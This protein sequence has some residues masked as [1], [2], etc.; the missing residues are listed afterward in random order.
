MN[1]RLIALKVFGQVRYEAGHKTTFSPSARII[2]TNRGGPCR[3]RV[4]SHCRIEGELL[5]FAHGGTISIGDWCFIGPGTRIWSGKSITLGNR[6]LVAHNVNIFDNLTHPIDP[7]ER[8]QHF[9]HILEHGHPRDISLADAPVVIEDDVWIGAGATI[10]RGVRLGRGAVIGA[11]AVVTKNVQPLAVVGG[12]PAR[13]I[14]YL[15]PSGQG[16]QGRDAY[17][18]S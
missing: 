3:V 11:G 14:R 15:E 6:V 17:E 4:G 8:H 10:L 12:C 2:D 9:Q 13:V 16:A 1:L 7:M 5:V 18:R